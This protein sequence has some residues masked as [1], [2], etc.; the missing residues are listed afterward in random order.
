M[1][2][3]DID[4]NH[5]YRLE[6]NPALSSYQNCYWIFVV[7][8]AAI[9]VSTDGNNDCGLTPGDFPFTCDAEIRIRVTVYTAGSW[10]VYWNIQ[11]G[12]CVKANGGLASFTA[13]L[14]YTDGLNGLS[15]DATFSDP[16]CCLDIFT[17][18]NMTLVGV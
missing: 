7:E 3:T 4:L 14:K 10:G 18:M 15:L 17:G 2:F 13:I 6:F 16:D 11:L 1:V 9:L 8:N 5:T 12:P